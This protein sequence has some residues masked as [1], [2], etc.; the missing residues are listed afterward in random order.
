MKCR[1]Y[2][3]CP[4]GMLIARCRGGGCTH[5]GGGAR[6]WGFRE[7]AERARRGGAGQA[8]ARHAAAPQRHATAARPQR[9]VL[10]CHLQHPGATEA[11][12]VCVQQ[13]QAARIQ[14]V[15]SERLLH[16]A[17]QAAQVAREGAKPAEAARA[18]RRGRC[19]EQG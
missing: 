3:S 12:V 17:R 5:E 7:A 11:G 8:G 6:V 2:R 10:S 16:R 15:D 1:P 9:S 14:H 18:R 13:R 4:A 19:E